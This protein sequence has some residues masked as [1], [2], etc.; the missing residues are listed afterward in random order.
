[1]VGDPQLVGAGGGGFSLG[2]VHRARPRSHPGPLSAASSTSDA[3]KAHLAYQTLDGATCHR[4]PLTV[5]LSLELPRA[6]VGEG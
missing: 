3:F 6:V 4:D 1:M 2:Q 5:E